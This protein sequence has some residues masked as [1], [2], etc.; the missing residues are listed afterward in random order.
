MKR[1]LRCLC[2]L[3][4]LAASVHVLASPAPA[5]AQHDPFTSAIARFEARLA[6]DVAADSVG[7]I[8]ACV[9]D[10]RRVVW[11]RGFGWADPAL[12]VPATDRTVYRTGS[13]SKSVTAVLLMDLAEEGVVGLEEPVERYLPELQGLA[14]RPEN[15]GPITFRQLASHTAGLER[16]PGIR[17]MASGPIASW[18]ARI[19]ES[20]PETEYRSPPATEYSYSNI[21]YGILGYALE[22]AADTSF[23]DMVRRR[24]FIPLGMERAEFVVSPHIA[25]LLAVG[26]T[27]RRDGSVDTAGPASEHLGRGY[28]VPNGGVYASVHDLARFIMLQTGAL[29]A[30]LEPESLRE[31]QRIQT[32]GPG[33]EGYG[34]GFS[35]RETQGRTLIGHGGS[36]AGYTAHMLFDPDSRIGVVLLR[37]YNRGKTSLGGAARRLLLELDE[38]RDNPKHQ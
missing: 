5:A 32:P 38:I 2:L 9:V 26:H 29:H 17:G 14:G 25:G 21:G 3:A 27:N 22:R 18:T 4:V 34:L 6:S 37:N 20:I 10:G 19:L 11:A 28:K 30:V 12:R 16:E 13:I 1:K 31:M 8:S 23:M 24:I 7:A 15:A 35:I 33:P 36:V